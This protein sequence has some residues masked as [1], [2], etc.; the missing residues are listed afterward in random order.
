MQIK[1]L[2]AKNFRCFQSLT[3]DFEAPTILL[4]GQNGSG[5]TS[6]IEALHYLCY[7]RSFRTSA[8]KELIGL[9]HESFFLKV[10]FNDREPVQVGFSSRK[11]NVR[12]GDKTIRSHKE[13]IEHF[14]IITLTE[15]NLQ[16][17]SEGPEIRRAL[18]DHQV[19]LHEPHL[20]KLYS[21]YKKTLD[22]RNF[23]LKS[24]RVSVD[25][26]HLWTD[27]LL[28]LG[29][30]IQKHRRNQLKALEE[31]IINLITNFFDNKLEISF[32]YQESKALPANYI[33]F[34]N[35]YPDL[36]AKEMYLARSLIGPHLDDFTIHFNGKN[37]KTFASRG[38]KKLITLLVK[39]AQ[40]Q[41][42]SK[43]NRGVIFLLDDFLTDFDEIRIKLAVKMLNALNCQLVFSCPLENKAIQD[44]LVDSNGQSIIINN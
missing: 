24:G 16:F 10:E 3:L 15:D 29:I 1:K 9:T 32:S 18:I 42:F 39:A 40:A 30:Q 2:T 17:I 22:N 35:T 41:Y 25:N 27:K 8:P 37:A 12:I 13:L 33:D 21:D 11:R 23:L 19:L 6:I 34:E 44:L 38:Q 20:I 7:L 26:Y 31:G 5:K 36:K 28:E 43:K 4:T 14:C